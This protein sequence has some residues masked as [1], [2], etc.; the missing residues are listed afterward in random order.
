MYKRQVYYSILARTGHFDLSELDT[1]R[2]INSRLQ[3]HPTNHDGLPG[4]N[5]ST[6]SLGQG[7]SVGIGIALSKKLKNFDS[8]FYNPTFTTNE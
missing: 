3:G 7:L 5:V 6:G 8:E 1:F 2:K 4:V